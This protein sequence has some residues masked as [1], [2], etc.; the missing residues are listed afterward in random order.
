MA[1]APVLDTVYPDYGVVSG[2]TYVAINGTAED[3]IRPIAVKFGDFSTT[4][5]VQSDNDM[6]V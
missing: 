4:E 5:L 1:V 2:G 6:L 3:R